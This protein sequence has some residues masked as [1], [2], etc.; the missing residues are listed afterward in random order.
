MRERDAQ[1][2][3]DDPYDDY[4]DTEGTANDPQQ[5]SGRSSTGIESYY[6]YSVLEDDSS[7]NSEA[8]QI[9]KTDDVVKVDIAELESRFKR[10]KKQ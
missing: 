3:Y 6:A 1:N 9:Y 10:G 7:T 8:A 4:V 5:E 2:P